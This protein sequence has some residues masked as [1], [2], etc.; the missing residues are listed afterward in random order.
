MNNKLVVLGIFVLVVF[1]AYIKS[2]S[3]RNS[4]RNDFNVANATV[5]SVYEF[6][7]SGNQI[8]VEFKF[9]ISDKPRI[10]SHTAIVC[11]KSNLDF[12]KRLL[13]GKTMQVFYQKSNPE[14]CEMG[15]EKS[16]YNKYDFK[17]PQELSLLI[18][19]IDSVC[20]K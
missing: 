4:L 15:L 3:D 19:S 14:N 17:V 2:C 1:F 16:I 11:G 7:N 13:V 12:M 18:N 20:I 5:L 10:I 8:F 9:S 6:R